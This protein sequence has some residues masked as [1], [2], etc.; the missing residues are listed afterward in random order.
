MKKIK[1]LFIA[2]FAGLMVQVMFTSCKGTD[3]TKEIATL[4]SVTV[5]LD[6]AEAEVNKIDTN[7]IGPMYRQIENDLHY[8]EIFY[9]NKPKEEVIDKQFATILSDY[10]SL[11]KPLRNSL[12]Q[13]PK[14]KTDIDY[15]QSQIENLVHDLEKNLVDKKDAT[16]FVN[17]E[18]A[19]AN[20][21]IQNT[22]YI[23]IVLKDVL[24]RYDEVS[25]R[26]RA[27]I[28]SLKAVEVK[29]AK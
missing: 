24:P 11:R 10:R 29:G 16:Q 2:A 22:G 13:V 19:E 15:A 7:R 3:Y 26:V 9:R 20:K 21:V 18:K 4:D 27:Y 5:K 12:G 23:T 6:S 1:V 28:D 25:P 8:V 14:L 17:K